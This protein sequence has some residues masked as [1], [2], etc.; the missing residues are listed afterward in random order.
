[1]SSERFQWFMG[2]ETTHENCLISGTRGK[3]VVCLPINIESWSWTC[4]N[5]TVSCM[6]WQAY[7][8]I[9]SM[10][11]FNLYLIFVCDVRLASYQCG[12]QTA[13]CIQL[14]QRSIW[15]SS[16]N[17]QQHR[18]QS[19]RSIKQYPTWAKTVS[20]AFV[21]QACLI[22]HSLYVSRFGSTE[23]V[24]CST[25]LVHSSTEY[26]CSSFVPLQGKY[27]SLVLA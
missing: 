16:G 20:A 18:L 22:Q 10:I 19:N 15:W 25:Y 6:Y 21:L 5:N 9:K 11:T 3:A 2:T 4:T 14:S 1:M 27:R 26:V 24:H 7:N 13:A 12:R 17:T 23:N 8:S